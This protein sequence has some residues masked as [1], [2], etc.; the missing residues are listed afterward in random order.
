MIKRNRLKCYQL[1]VWSMVSQSRPIGTLG[2]HDRTQRASTNL[3][4]KLLFSAGFFIY[5]YFKCLFFKLIAQV[6]TFKTIFIIS[7]HYHTKFLVWLLLLLHCF[8]R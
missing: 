7:N 3:K 4:Q 2:G 6:P 5:S 8:V 1:K